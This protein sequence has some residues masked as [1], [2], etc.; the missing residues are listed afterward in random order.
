MYS[1]RHSVFSIA[2]AVLALATLTGTAGALAAP[3]AGDPVFIT[4]L[5]YTINAPGSYALAGNLTGTGGIVINASR[6]SL[7]LRGFNLTGVPGSTDAIF[8]RGNRSD[9]EIWNGT[10]T[11]WGGVG[12]QGESAFNSSF[13]DL[14]LSANG[15]CGLRAGHGAVVADVVAQNNGGTGIQGAE[16]LVVTDSS[17]AGN[18]AWGFELGTGSNIQGCSALHNRGGGIFVENGSLVRGNTAYGNGWQSTDAALSACGAAT[19]GGIAVLGEGSRVDG[20]TV[21]HN[22]IGLQLH[23]GGNSVSG[24]MAS[25]NDTNYQFESGN[26]LELMLCE[27]P[28]TISWPAK[29]TLAGTLTGVAGED[30]ITV[31][32]DGVTIDMLDHGLIGVPGSLCGIRVLAG[33]STFHVMDGFLSGWGNCG[34]NSEGAMDGRIVQVCADGNGMDGLRVGPS[35]TILDC[36]ASHNGT[37]GIRTDQDCT[38]TGVTSNNNAN[39]GVELGMHSNITA[40]TASENVA[41]G[42]RA[43]RGSQ[44]AHSTASRNSMG[45]AVTVGCTVESC[46]TSFNGQVGIRAEKQC[47][48]LS[49]LSDQNGTGIFVLDGPGTRVEG[50]NLSNNQLGLNIAAPGNLAVRNSSWADFMAYSFDPGSSFGPVVDLAAGGALATENPWANFK[51]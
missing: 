4:A 10:I 41:F 37:D 47:L 39:D 22:T 31:D 9:I 35:S 27:L 2:V 45:I 51:K 42:I 19:L 30:G 3:G 38:V 20:N 34:L 5:P 29:V 49:N 16:A 12:I 6:V 46:T 1:L 43:A 15:M 7:D 24:N 25:D 50:N 40:S 26:M 21:C 17:A 48:L 23:S 13:H 33:H 32:A 18:V 28:Q 36:T 14:R 11:A 8:V 44:V